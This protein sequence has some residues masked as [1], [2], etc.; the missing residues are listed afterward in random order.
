MPESLIVGTL[1]EGARYDVD[2]RVLEFV[3]WV[4][5]AGNPVDSRELEKMNPWFFFDEE[6]V[7]LGPTDDGIEPVFSFD[8]RGPR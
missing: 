1:V 4:D 8:T 5:R 7:F 3:R 6:D 2:L